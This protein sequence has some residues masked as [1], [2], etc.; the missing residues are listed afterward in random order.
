MDTDDDLA[1][2]CEAVRIAG[3]VAAAR[4]RSTGLA[5]TQKSGPGDVVTEADREAEAAALDHLRLRRPD[6]GAVGE[7]G[8]HRPGRR[9][10]FVD[11][12]DGTLDHV[13][14]DPTWCSAV[15]R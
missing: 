15:P 10:W 12:I 6:D 5:V 3:E 7:E 9:T 14:G 8:G 1:A 2:A 13:A 4:F 11:A